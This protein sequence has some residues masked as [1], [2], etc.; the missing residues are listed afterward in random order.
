M[1]LQ[2]LVVDGYNVIRACKRYRSLVDEAYQDPILHDVYVRART[3]LVRDVAGFAHGKYRPVIVF[4]GFGNPDPERPERTSGGVQII[5]SKYGIE[6]DS[7]IE[8][9]VREERDAGRPVTVVTSDSF[10]QNTVYGE[11]VT[12]LSAR[13]FDDETDALARQL[14]DF[15]K[16]PVK[17]G[18]VHATVADRIPKDVAKKLHEMAMPKK[19]VHIKTNRGPTKG[20]KHGK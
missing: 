5:F 17:P 1:P 14:E 9:M 7:I 2:L 3:A 12:R 19:Q 8:R 11:G 20:A 10:I 16:I 4:D 6:A 18:P 13:M 15:K